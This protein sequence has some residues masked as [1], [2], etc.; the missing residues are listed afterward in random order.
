MP[1]NRMAKAGPSRSC[2]SRASASRSVASAERTESWASVASTRASTCPAL[3]RWPS[4][5]GTATSV[6][7]VEKETG[8][9]V[10][11]AMLPVADA[12]ARTTPRCAVAVR[13]A[14]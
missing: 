14:A 9:S 5:T 12:D 6:P 2:C 7:P 10:G 8:S 13:G 3:T 4:F 11:V 1:T